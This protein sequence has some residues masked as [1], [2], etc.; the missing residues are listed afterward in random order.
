MVFNKFR[1]IIH[2]LENFTKFFKEESCGT[3]TPCRAG[4]QIL[5]EKIKKLKS[6]ICTKTDLEE[7]K[8]WSKI[9]QVTSR[10]GLGQ[11]CAST[12]AMAIDKFEAYFDL[13]VL[14]DNL[15][16]NVEFDMENAVYDYDKL[17]K[18]TQNHKIESKI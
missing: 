3:C 10:C 17:I 16:A 7:V 11:F 14:D 1:S 18:T 6:G 2:I 9:I 8:E 13:K 12:F 4:N 5:H 15:E